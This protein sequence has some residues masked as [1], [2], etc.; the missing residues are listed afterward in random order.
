[1]K[2]HHL[3][4]FSAR[5]LRGRARSLFSI[6]LASM[7]L[8]ALPVS[9]GEKEPCDGPFWEN[10]PGVPGMDAQVHAFAEFNGELYAAGQFLMASG[11]TVN[12]IARWNGVSWTPL[13][14]AEVGANNE[15]H[16]LEV[17]D[18]A[19]HVGGRFTSIGGVSALR[20]ARFDG[21]S[22]S[23][24]GAGFND[25]VYA[26]HVHNGE[27]YAGGRFSNSGGAGMNNV[28]RF[29]GTA[30][31][32]LGAGTS[33]RVEALASF[34][35]DLYVG[36]L[37]NS[38]GG[39]FVSRVARWDGTEW[40]A[41]DGGVGGTVF[42]LIPFDGDL[43][44]GGN[45]N[46]VGGDN[47]IRFLAAWDGTAW[48]PSVAP[49]LNSRVEAL[50][51]FDDGMGDALFIGGNFT[52][53]AGINARRIARLDKK[54]GWSSL[55]LGLPNAN[56]RVNTLLTFFDPLLD[57]VALFVGGNFNNTGGLTA[58]N[59][60]RWSLCVEPD[61]CI[62][63]W[64]TASG[65]PG[66]SL[67]DPGSA[68]SGWVFDLYEWA[69]EDVR[70]VSEPSLFAGGFFRSAGTTSDLFSLARYDG[71]V[72]HALP[73][74]DGGLGIGG[75]GDNM[76]LGPFFVHGFEAFPFTE[77][78]T[79]ERG[80]AGPSAQEVLYV[81][82]RFPRVSEGAGL[83]Q[84]LAF[85][86]GEVLRD[87][88]WLFG[89]S[90]FELGAVLALERAEGALR[91]TPRLYAGGLFDVV[92]DRG[93]PGSGP[94]PMG[95][96][97]ALATNVAVYDGFSWSQVGPDAS[98]PG[99]LSTLFN[100]VTSLAVVTDDGLENVFITLLFADAEVTD[101]FAPEG[102]PESCVWR[103]DGESW[104][105]L[106]DLP[107]LGFEV[108]VVDLGDGPTLVAA[109]AMLA[110]QS[111]DRGD[112]PEV[113]GF[114]AEWDG[115]Q[116]VALGDAE[117]RNEN[118]IG[119][120][121]IGVVTSVRVFDDGTGPA[122]YATGFFDTVGGDLAANNIARWDGESWSALEE[123]ITLDV[124]AKLMASSLRTLGSFAS[125][126]DDQPEG[127]IWPVLSDYLNVVGG[128][129]MEP[130]RIGNAEGESLY[131][132]GLFDKAG[133]M[134]AKGMAAW[135]GCDEVGVPPCEGL[136]WDASLGQPGVTSL[137]DDAFPGDVLTL[138][139]LTPIAD[140]P[141]GGVSASYA[142]GEFL[143][144]GVNIAAVDGVAV[145]GL[146]RGNVSTGALFPDIVS[147]TPL[148]SNSTR[149]ATTS[150]S[151]LGDS[152][153]IT[154]GGT[155]D[156]VTTSAGSE[157][158]SSAGNVFQFYTSGNVIEGGA[159]ELL[160][161]DMN[162]GVNLQVF[163]TLQASAFGGDALRGLIDPTRAVFVGG[164]F[165]QAGV[166]DKAPI[167]PERGVVVPEVETNAIALW[168]GSEW[169]ALG[170]AGGLQIDAGP[171]N[172]RASV[173]TAFDA[174][175][176]G[177]P[178]LIVAGTFDGVE[179]VGPAR[180]GGPSTEIIAM[181]NIGAYD[182]LTDQWFGI[183]EGVGSPSVSNGA[184]TI[185]TA[186]A[187]YEDELYAFGRFTQAPEPE[188]DNFEFRGA[189]KWNGTEWVDISEGLF[190]V[191]SATAVTAVVFDDGRGPALFIGSEGVEIGGEGSGEFTSG[192]ARWDGSEWTD[193]VDEPL[194][195]VF[196]DSE[197]G[198]GG[199]SVFPGFVNVL[200]PMQDPDTGE[201]VLIV[202]GSFTNA[203]DEPA[204]G[205]ATLRPCEDLPP[206]GAPVIVDLLVDP[207]GG[208][209]TYPNSVMFFVAATSPNCDGPLTYQWRRNGVDLIDDGRIMG[210][211][212][213][214]LI[215]NPA[216]FDDLGDYSVRVDN[217]CDG[218]VSDDIPLTV[219]CTGDYNGDGI[220]D[221]ADLSVVLSDFGGDFDFSDLSVV[222]ANFG[223]DC[224]VLPN[225]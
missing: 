29:D 8:L 125:G 86:D 102:G 16:A 26:L 194:T 140:T 138:L 42:A 35:G 216:L 179:V 80:A 177:R 165:T 17:F 68:I 204:L 37:F 172:P 201:D 56:S 67:F 14:G 40:F 91:G 169:F 124:E 183:G 105:P 109:G 131:V 23:Q 9:A 156:G 3:G 189:A 52:E 176:L 145:T 206:S 126:R 127:A 13:P 171:L 112:D 164:N 225:N 83:T 119:A 97:G 100:P 69:P 132:G 60:S 205:I 188:G 185:V 144:G 5:S 114:V 209:V 113:I 181:N 50:A 162:G 210:A 224:N 75:V 93:F 58:N 85:W 95:I 101:G 174:V 139:D 82:G 51:T 46:N 184:L 148:L 30:W 7:A 141:R 120:P 135:S 166:V 128:R 28:A 90:K 212:T 73:N 193:P 195:F 11:E 48:M 168:T 92:F 121:A 10:T 55:G 25:D 96:S 15:I 218:V 222:L 122:L 31:T 211:Q 187:V 221:F 186:L 191:V 115:A 1:M 123:G 155:F 190:D 4:S 137:D 99:G 22:W 173:M 38:A 87:S 192:L 19:L 53:V 198:S 84:S 154:Y 36:G 118:M 63:G 200:L 34:Q 223:V 44:V 167:D 158:D 61:I 146:A 142:P 207:E 220:V 111:G 110:M 161:D 89:I 170:G 175:G 136:V 108:R 182:P 12:R 81:A 147:V 21:A 33:S 43:Y 129:T 202:G 152:F 157:G 199:V 71:S 72:W 41:L 98:T 49:G 27:L 6:A 62:P 64:D 197:L 65:N 150:L 103:F 107:G 149:V 70:G 76:Q 78:D 208:E 88:R 94:P 203:G 74:E 77:M 54:N 180:G 214:T 116:W 178:Q 117:F 32:A 130:S 217:D 45:F 143:I 134:T 104:A 39:V 106:G 219:I 20:V 163:S 133:G 160:F 79:A 151:A 47:T 66:T 24:V 57:D 159:A 59:V 213:P 2:S 215:I 196:V 153:A 18:G